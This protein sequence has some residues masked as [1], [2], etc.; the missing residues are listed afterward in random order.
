MYGYNYSV[1]YRV[2]VWLALSVWEITGSIHVVFHNAK[3]II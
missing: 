3:T 2:V 1:L